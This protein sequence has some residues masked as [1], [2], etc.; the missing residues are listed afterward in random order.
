MSATNTETDQVERW[1]G[2][3]LAA[4]DISRTAD[5]DARRLFAVSRPKIGAYI[6]GYSGQFPL[7]YR[8]MVRILWWPI[9]KIIQPIIMQMIIELLMYRKGMIQFDECS[10]CLQRSM[11][12]EGAGEWDKTAPHH[13]T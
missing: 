8:T 4:Y 7:G 5:P 12:G 6:Q 9:F 1:D 11:A 10:Q 2:I 3:N 13:L